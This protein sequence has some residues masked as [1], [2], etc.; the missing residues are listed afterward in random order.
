MRRVSPLGED[1]ATRTRVPLAL[2]P[3]LLLP[4]LLALAPRDLWA[5]EEPRFGISAHEMAAEGDWLVTR[6]SGK[7]D[8]EKP[9][10]LFWMVAGIEVVVGRATSQGARLPSALL[11]AL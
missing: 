1:P 8:A 10:L 3:F 11:A 2:L 6:I 4:V 9:P 5:P 7:V